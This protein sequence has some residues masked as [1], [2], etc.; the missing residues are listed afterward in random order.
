[1]D[2]IKAFSR[3]ACDDMAIKTKASIIWIILLQSRKISM[4]NT[5]IL[6]ELS[7]IHT[8]F[9]SKECLI[10]IWE[11]PVKILG[12]TQTKLTRDLDSGT[13]KIPKKPKGW[14]PQG[15]SNPNTWHPLLKS[16]LLSPIGAV[17]RPSFSVVLKYCG[18]TVGEVYPIIDRKCVPNDLFEKCYLSDKCPRNHRILT[19]SQASKVLETQKNP[20]SN[21]QKCN[22]FSDLKLKK[23]ITNGIFYS[24]FI[25]YIYHGSNYK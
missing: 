4:E 9:S 11:V 17:W 25:W 20:L 21:L 7:T 18:K 12:N 2:S 10:I 24:L 19:D 16:T 8:K 6:A 23:H 14:N 5:A 3:V 13:E 15:S 1:M 22:K